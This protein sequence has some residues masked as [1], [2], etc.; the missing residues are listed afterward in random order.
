MHDNGPAEEVAEAV[1]SATQLQQ[2][3]WLAGDTM[4]RP[5][6]ELDVGHFPLSRL[7]LE[8]KMC[9]GVKVLAYAYTSTCTHKDALSCV[10]VCSLHRGAAGRYR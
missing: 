9:T 5:A 3:V 1:D 2:Q 7:I 8:L 4:I 10:S 6:G